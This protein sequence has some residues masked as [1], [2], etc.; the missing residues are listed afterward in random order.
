MPAAGKR[1]CGALLHAVVQGP[2]P[3]IPCP[4]SPPRPRA[5]F[6]LSVW[7]FPVSKPFIARVCILSQVFFC[8]LLSSSVSMTLLSFTYPR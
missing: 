1:W 3:T 2:R 8:S 5:S 6:C 4:A 7:F